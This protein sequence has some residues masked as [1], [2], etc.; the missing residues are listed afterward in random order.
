MLSLSTSFAKDGR[1]G[2]ETNCVTLTDRHYDNLYSD[3]DRN[4]KFCLVAENAR[5]VT[6]ICFRTADVQHASTSC[7]WR[8]WSICIY[9][10]T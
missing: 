4:D 6:K 3:E 2:A 8:T 5:V 10:Y 9:T 7:T 1:L